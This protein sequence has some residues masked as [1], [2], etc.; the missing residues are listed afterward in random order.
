MQLSGWDEMN[1]KK[2][3][4]SMLNFFLHI[5]RTHG[6]Q[7]YREAQLVQ[8]GEHKVM[9]IKYMK[10]ILSFVMDFI[11]IPDTHCHRDAMLMLVA[12]P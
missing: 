3:M 2:N 11:E 9:P 10:A 7:Y 4:L 8:K 1:I 6:E 12:S 5:R